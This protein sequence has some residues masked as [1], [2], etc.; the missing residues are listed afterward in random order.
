MAKKLFSF[1]ITD[2]D[3]PEYFGKLMEEHHIEFYIV[4]G[5][6]FGFSK[7]GF[8]IKDDEDFLRAKKLFTE[9]EEIYA[10]LAR[11][12][13]QNETGYNPGATKE[14]KIQFWIQYLKRKRGSL[15]LVIFGFILI[16]WYFSLFFDVLNNPA[17]T[18]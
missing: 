7:P 11:Q 2:D 13:Y 12:K 10:E 9:H 18:G 3:E 8:W 6:V 1:P 16:F 14:E 15:I 17:K 5:S 4:P